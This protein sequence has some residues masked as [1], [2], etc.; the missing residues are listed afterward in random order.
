MMVTAGQ[1]RRLNHAREQESHSKPPPL[2]G[3][4]LRSCMCCRRSFKSVGPSNR[5]CTECR[6]KSEYP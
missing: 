1:A 5:L 2:H 4:R 3:V 6:H